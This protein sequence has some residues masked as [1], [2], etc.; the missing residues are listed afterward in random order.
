M[1]SQIQTPTIS[2]SLTK[3]V[4]SITHFSE[5][6][7]IP[8]AQIYYPVK[9]NSHPKLIAKMAEWG[10]NF[11]AGAVSECEQ[12]VKYGVAPHQIRYGNPIKS[13]ESIARAHQL[14]ITSFGADTMEELEKIA[15][16]APKS[17]VYIRVAVNNAGAEWA[18][19]EKFG[20]PANL[21]HELFE[22][23]QKQRLNMFGISFHVGWN[24][25]QLDTWK[26]VFEEMQSLVS[27]LKA[28]NHP[29][30]SVN[31]GGGFPAHSGNQF[32]KME[33][34]AAVIKPYLE[35][36]KQK[37]NMEVIAEP[38]SYLV[39]NAGTMFVKVIAR[40]KRNDLDWVYVDSGIFQGF[41]W[42]MGGLQYHLEA[43]E[44]N[45]TELQPMVVCG[46]TCDTHDVYSH[47]VM[48]P[49]NIRV[50]DI[51][52]ISPAGAYISSSKSYNGF[53][54]PTEEVVEE[55]E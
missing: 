46:P 34:I 22:H 5:S 4:Q 15:L 44:I 12:L 19:T 55:Q 17:S 10:L 8:K 29:I 2:L 24:N 37:M 27:R 11:E 52:T 47:S 25:E 41:S 18:L 38:G 49:K 39:A 50:G 16:L 6:L 33:K 36:F 43:L 53:D 30:T 42:I 13:A 14:G 9:V 51:L 7:G 54:F 23:G 26:N 1:A 45:N 20:C 21:V 28:L 3:V 32:E 48:L 40:V 35:H 31:I